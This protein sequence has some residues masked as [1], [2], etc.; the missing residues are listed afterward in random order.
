[1]HILDCVDPIRQLEMINFTNRTTYIE[2]FDDIHR[3]I[4]NFI[5]E[6]ISFIVKAG[7]YG[8]MSTT[9]KIIM[10]YY[11]LNFLSNTATLRADK[12]QKKRYFK[13][14][15]LHLYLHISSV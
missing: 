4:L 7:K 6:N 5:S 11:V 10:G 12:P 3:V 14:V 9:Y 2:D 1:M 13:Q 8:A 15:N